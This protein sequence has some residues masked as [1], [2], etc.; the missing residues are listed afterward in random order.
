MALRVINDLIGAHTMLKGFQRM[1]DDI[2]KVYEKYNLSF[3]VPVQK[4]PDFLFRNEILL[5]TFDIYSAY[6]VVLYNMNLGFSYSDN[7]NVHKELDEI[8]NKIQYP[9]SVIVEVT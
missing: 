9:F 2:L 1:N 3:D 8:K 7:N 6:N 5:N 4:F